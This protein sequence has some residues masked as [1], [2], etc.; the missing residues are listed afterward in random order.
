MQF[1]V[2]LMTG[3]A[4]FYFLSRK[5]LSLFI[6]LGG[7]TLFAMISLAFYFG[8]KYYTHATPQKAQAAYDPTVGPF[9][10]VPFAKGVV[11]LTPGNGQSFAAWYMKKGLLGWRMSG[12]SN[13]QYDLS[14]D[15]YNVDFEP[16]SDNG[17]TFV[18]GT[19]MIPIKEIQYHHD[20]KTFTCE[21]GHYPVWHMILPFSQNTFEHSDWTMV[22]PDGKTAPL[23]K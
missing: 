2:G 4:V 16:F 12:I 18:W 13:A 9:E 14:A 23:F 10:T 11:L 22:L 20:G 17:E 1:F 8:H 3:V 7:I 21:V 15:N 5:K 6:R 19:S